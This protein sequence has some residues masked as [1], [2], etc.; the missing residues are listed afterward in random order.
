M[1]LELVAPDIAYRDS[2]FAALAEFEAEG[3]PWWANVRAAAEGDFAGFVAAKLA[4]ARPADAHQIPKTHLW[5]IR[6]ACFVG[7]IAIHHRID[8]ALRLAGGHIGYDTV[9]SCRGRGI[10]TA[11][12]RR[13]LP[14]ARDLGLGEVLVTCDDGNAGSIK[15]IERNAGR[16]ADVARLPTG[17]L[18]RYYWIDLDRA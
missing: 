15:V 9:P 13:A 6:D 3:L 18:K 5:A 11:M 2:F 7:R 10:A 14:V 16:L 8:D 1:N 12:L 4:E 17:V